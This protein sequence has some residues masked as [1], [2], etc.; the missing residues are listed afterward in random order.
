MNNEKI[1]FKS[2]GIV[3]SPHTELSDIPIQPVFSKGIEGKVVVET[4]YVQG[5]QDLQ[6]FSH[7]YL[8]YY[9]HR[10][11]ETHLHETPYL[12]NESH[13]VFATRSP[14]RP[15]KL[16]V[17]LVRLIRIEG[18]TL[19]INDVD[20]LNGTPLLDIKPYIQ[21]FDSKEHVRSGWQDNISDEKASDKG[22][23][24]YKK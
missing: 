17:S 2:I 10:S 14:H 9:F 21:R 13:G 12:S 6:S 7:I 15:N 19:F 16:G 11:E 3:Y 1:V 18:N 8:Y 22:K 20:I 23:R 4:A 5:L 24:N